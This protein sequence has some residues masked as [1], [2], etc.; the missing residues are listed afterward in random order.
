MDWENISDPSQTHGNLCLVIGM[1]FLYLVLIVCSNDHLPLSQFWKQWPTIIHITCM[2]INLYVGC[3]QF[4]GFGSASAPSHNHRTP[5]EAD[6]HI[7][8][9]TTDDDD[10]SKENR[11]M[12]RLRHMVCMP[13]HDVLIHLESW[14]SLGIFSI[15]HFMEYRVES[16]VIMLSKRQTRLNPIHRMFP[17][18]MYHDTVE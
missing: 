2:F 12:D 6:N 11:E 17:I 10:V 13:W 14:Y 3:F 1:H 16:T 18:L 5:V 15:L 7:A 8:E 4:S 9:S